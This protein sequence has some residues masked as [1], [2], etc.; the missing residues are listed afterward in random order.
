MLVLCKYADMP[1]GYYIY[2][3]TLNYGKLLSKAYRPTFRRCGVNAYL[4]II[5][6]CHCGTGIRPL[7]EVLA[8]STLR[9]GLSKVLNVDLNDDQWLQLS[10]IVAYR[11]GRAPQCPRLQMLAPSAFLASAASTSALQ[12][13][14]LTD[15]VN[16]CCKTI[17]RRDLFT[18]PR[19]VYTPL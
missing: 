10:S 15:S 16:T 19:G 12:Q 13:S 9:A 4:F 5:T 14:I 18:P 17:F 2:T 6:Y 7:N 11:R 8:D 1:H 3:N